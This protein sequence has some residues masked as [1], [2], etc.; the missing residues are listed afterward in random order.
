M[1]TDEQA[2]YARGSKAAAWLFLSVF[3]VGIVGLIALGA[4]M[5]VAS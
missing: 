4:W 1:S 2:E 5:G 3:A